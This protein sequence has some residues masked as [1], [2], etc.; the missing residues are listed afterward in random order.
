MFG[1]IHVDFDIDIWQMSEILK[2]TE[3]PPK[4]TD[5][6]ALPAVHIKETQ[7]TFF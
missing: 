2:H 6:F 3:S 5:T 7:N 1:G 4:M